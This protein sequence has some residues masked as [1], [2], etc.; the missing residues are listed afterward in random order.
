MLERLGALFSSYAFLCQLCKHRF[1]AFQKS[2]TGPDFSPDRR[3]FDRIP[4]MFP[5]FFSGKQ[6]QGRGVIVDLSIGGCWITSERSPGIGAVLGLEIYDTEK[7]QPIEIDAAVVRLH[8]GMGFACE[9]LKLRAEH[10]ERLKTLLEHCW[11]EAHP[12]PS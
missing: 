11:S 6:V 3:A 5:T 4:V 10:E 1:R 12:S 2:P 7:G 8:V 9:F